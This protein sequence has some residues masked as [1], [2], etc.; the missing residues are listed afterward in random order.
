MAGDADWP[1]VGMAVLQAAFLALLLYLQLTVFRD[2]HKGLVRAYRRTHDVDDLE[3]S[4]AYLFNALIWLVYAALPKFDVFVLIWQAQDVGQRTVLPYV[5]IWMNA[6]S[7]VFYGSDSPGQSQVSTVLRF[8][9][10]RATVG[11]YMYYAHGWRRR[12]AVRG[13]GCP[14][15]CIP[16]AAALPSAHRV[17]GPTQGIRSSIGSFGC[18]TAVFMYLSTVDQTVRAYRRTHDVND[19]EMS[20]AYLFNALI[21]LVY[22]ALPKFDVFVLIWQAQDVGQRTV[23]PYV[24]I[25]MNAASLV[26]YGS[27]SPG[28]SPVSTVLRFSW[29]RATVGFYMYY[30]HG[31]RRRLAVRG[32]GCPPSCIPGAAALPSAH[33]VQGPTQGIRSSIGSFG[34]VTAVFMYLST[35]DQTVRAYRRTHDVNDLEMSFAYLFNALIWLVYA[36]LPKFDV[37]VLSSSILGVLATGYQ[38]FLWV[39][40]QNAPILQNNVVAG[41]A[42]SGGL[43]QPPVVPPANDPLVQ[44]NAGIAEANGAAVAIDQASGAAA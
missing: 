13:H 21:W 26:F 30:A 1:Y 40:Y 44:R 24:S 20:F 5:S 7:L 22:A 11:F 6:A 28:Q 19:L 34:C 12:L 25:W 42:M 15:S 41:I 43:V 29:R 36:A 14:P 38:A 23:L 27:D 2:P 10:R 37:F 16:G 39:R 18:V 8:S 31:W 32:H 33:R 17:Q 35:V 9:W 4:F 3:M